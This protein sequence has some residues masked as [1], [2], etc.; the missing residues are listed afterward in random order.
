MRC[1]SRLKLLQAYGVGDEFHPRL[2]VT[3]DLSATTPVSMVVEALHLISPLLQHIRGGDFYRFTATTDVSKPATGA[4]R[5]PPLGIRDD[6]CEPPA[7][8]DKPCKAG[9]GFDT[10]YDAAVEPQDREEDDTA[11]MT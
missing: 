6:R 11:T 5:G 1:L 8:P 4:K 10:G 7:G 9:G 2:P 3:Y